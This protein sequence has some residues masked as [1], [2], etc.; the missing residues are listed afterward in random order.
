MNGWCTDCGHA[1]FRVE[2]AGLG[3]KGS[4]ERSRQG[5]TTAAATGS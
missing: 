1:L 5:S 3:E 4:T 2:V